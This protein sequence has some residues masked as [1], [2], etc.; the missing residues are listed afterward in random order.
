MDNNTTRSDQA[1][2]LRR[3]EEEL[4][5]RIDRLKTSMSQTSEIDTLVFKNGLMK[6]AQEELRRVQEKL[7]GVARD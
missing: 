7:T 2:R 4:L 1:E 3:R 5:A 6:Q